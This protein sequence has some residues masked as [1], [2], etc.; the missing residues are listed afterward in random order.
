MQLAQ[1]LYEDA[2]KS[3]ESVLAVKPN[4]QAARNGEV[5]AA[6]AD[7]LADQKA[8]IDGSAL[9]S[10]IRARKFVPDSPELLF[11]F[12]MQA[13]RMRVYRG[14][15]RSSDQSAHVGATRR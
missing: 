10:L 3:F 15:G 5:K 12:A 14:C 13:E 6:E 7:A 4:S 2:L 1:G 8:G 11:D 9:L